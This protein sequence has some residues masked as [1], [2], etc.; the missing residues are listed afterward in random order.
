MKIN[1]RIHSFLDGE[2]SLEALSEDEARLALQ[3]QS[4]LTSGLDGLL[5]AQVPDV[6][7]AVLR[8]I[9]QPSQASARP[10]SAVSAVRDALGW[11][12]NPRPMAIRPAYGLVAAGLLALFAVAPF[13]AGDG[14]DTEDSA[15]ASAPA[16]I[17][18][19]FR[20]DAPE[21][22][23]VSLAG[24]FTGWE[25]SYELYQTAPGVWTVSVALDPGVH[26]YAF[27]VDGERWT[28][29]PLAASVDDGFGGVNSRLSILPPNTSL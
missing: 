6:S 24:D 15:V 14:P 3:F 23:S 12:W 7:G 21:A 16:P 4:A 17:L 13:S 8:V 28:P 11:L 25:P 9:E 19:H 27:V 5:P 26:D 22:T 10:R 20:L 18:V 1:A 29:D 2:I